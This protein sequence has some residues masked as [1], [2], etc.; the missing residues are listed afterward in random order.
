VLLALKRHNH[1]GIVIDFARIT[2]EDQG[3]SGVGLPLDVVPRV[4]YGEGGPDGGLDDGDVR[5]IVVGCEGG[6]CE[7]WQAGFEG[8]DGVG[9]HLFKVG[10]RGGG[11][12]RLDWGGELCEDRSEEM[13]MIEEVI[14][15]PEGSTCSLVALR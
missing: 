1:N 14:E 6:G 4:G 15:I 5:V 7:C 13:R 10:G 9:W 11:R 2:N 8:E 12:E 3:G